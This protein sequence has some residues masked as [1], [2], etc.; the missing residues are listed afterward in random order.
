MPQDSLLR[1]DL[2]YV[3][4]NTTVGG[5]I[6]AGKADHRIY[7][8]NWLLVA[9]ANVVATW[10]SGSTPIGGAINGGTVGAAP[11]EAIFAGHLRCASGAALE[12][13]ADI[14][15]S[16]TGSVVVAFVPDVT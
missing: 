12:L 9:A 16:I 10:R 7:V 13:N 1:Y 8:V 3:N 11:G 5:V 2:K 4:I 14:T 15:P 6:V